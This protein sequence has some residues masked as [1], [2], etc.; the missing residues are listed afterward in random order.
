MSVSIRDNPLSNVWYSFVRSGLPVASKFSR[1]S[2]SNFSNSIKYFRKTQLE[3]FRLEG[4]GFTLKIGIFFY[5]YR[6]QGFL[7][8]DLLLRASQY[9]RDLC[10]PQTVDSLWGHPW[11]TLAAPGQPDPKWPGALWRNFAP[12][13]SSPVTLFPPNYNNKPLLQT[14]QRVF[15]RFQHDP[16]FHNKFLSE[17]HFFFLSAKS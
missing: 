2:K 5:I 10:C 12:S 11:R 16:T 13:A 17:W 15:I 8:I 4:L 7:W 9:P 14:S 3:I 1:F 6:W